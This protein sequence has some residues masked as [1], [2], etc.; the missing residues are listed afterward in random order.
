[1]ASKSEDVYTIKY[2]VAFKYY[3]QSQTRL[4]FYFK[5]NETSDSISLYDTERIGPSSGGGGGS[6]GGGSSGGGSDV[7]PIVSSENITLTRTSAYEIEDIME[8]E[9]YE[10]DMLYY[11]RAIVRS[12]ELKLTIT[13]KESQR[14]TFDLSLDKLAYAE[15]S[16]TDLDDYT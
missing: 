8:I 11:K 13:L 3:D 10:V 6:G 14:A 16:N 7:S 9:L 2:H 15:S 1:M 12:T 4:H 5:Y